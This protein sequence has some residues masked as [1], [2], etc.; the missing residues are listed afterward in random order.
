MMF[1]DRI[2]INKGIGVN[3]IEYNKKM[4]SLSLLAF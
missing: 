4:Y 2:G 1:Y 3:N